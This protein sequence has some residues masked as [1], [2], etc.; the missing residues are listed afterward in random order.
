LRY[1]YDYRFAVKELS[2]VVDIIKGV[3]PVNVSLTLTPNIKPLS[4]LVVIYSYKF[5]SPIAG[6]KLLE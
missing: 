5:P 3:Q 6:N 4:T 1:I 2:A